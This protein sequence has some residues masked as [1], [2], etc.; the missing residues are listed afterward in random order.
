MTPDGFGGAVLTWVDYRSSTDGDVYAQR[1]YPSG[2]AGWMAD[3]VP[4]CT[5]TEKQQFPVLVGDAAGGAIIGWQDHRDPYDHYVFA[6]RVAPQG[7]MYATGIETGD[8]PRA[9]P[10]LRQNRPN[11]FNPATLISYEI[12]ARSHVRLL[13]FG[14][15]GH[16][17]ATL[18][19]G[20]AQ[21]GSH[22][23]AWGGRDHEGRSVASG[24]Y[25]YR[26]EV[27][28]RAPLTRRMVLL[29]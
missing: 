14:P 2:M 22:Q 28:G 27:A 6:M 24:V 18:F 15:N 17:V 1:L 19:D 12:P 5:A 23:I 3:G 16:R 7:G 9:T 8:A 25:Y 10:Y 21:V 13:V 20:M 26:L 4:V 11:P 29:K